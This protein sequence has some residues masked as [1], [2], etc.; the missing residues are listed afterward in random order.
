MAVRAIDIVGVP[1]DL[2]A[3]HENQ[4]GKFAEQLILSAL[5]RSIL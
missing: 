5:G 3:D 1:M 2:G 4:T